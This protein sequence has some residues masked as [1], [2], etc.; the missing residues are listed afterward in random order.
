MFWSCP[1]WPPLSTTTA[2][3]PRQWPRL[4]PALPSY[5]LK[6]TAKIPDIGHLPGGHFGIKCGNSVD[7]M[8]LF[9]N[10]LHRFDEKFYSLRLP[11]G[12]ARIKIPSSSW[13]EARL[14]NVTPWKWP[15][16]NCLW[17]VERV[18]RATFGVAEGS[19]RSGVQYLREISCVA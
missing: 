19:G 2:M 1:Y 12:R 3:L 16:K 4:W 10:N 11:T 17:N 6:Q 8:W 7:G 14:K 15:G 13:N 18:G 9:Y 5:S